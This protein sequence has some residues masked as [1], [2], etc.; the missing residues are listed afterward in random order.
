[1]EI[2]GHVRPSV[3]THLL[4]LIAYY[5]EKDAIDVADFEFKHVNEIADLVKRENI[6]CDFELTKSFDIHTDPATAEK[7]KR[8]YLE[9]KR[10]GIAKSTIDDL[11][12]YD[13]EEAEKVSSNPS[14][15]QS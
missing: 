1:M 13:D 11:T 10:R 7:A 12:W 4:K 8:D 6:D 14:S 3:Y 2:G 5:N 15:K 9:L